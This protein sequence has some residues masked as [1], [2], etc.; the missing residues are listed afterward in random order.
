MC[1]SIYAFIQPRCYKKD[2]SKL[3]SNVQM[4]VLN[5]I[6]RLLDW[7]PFKPR[8]S[9][10]RNYLIIADAG[11]IYGLM[12][13]LRVLVWI[14]KLTARLVDSIFHDANQYT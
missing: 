5:L 4:L 7:L 12:S 3:N 6:S 2:Q 13:L 1:V 14:E 8:E 9:S 10:L 11:R